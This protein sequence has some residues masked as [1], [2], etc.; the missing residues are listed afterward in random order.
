[1]RGENVYVQGVR[2]LAACIVRKRTIISRYIQT[3]ARGTGARIGGVG[4]RPGGV[5]GEMGNGINI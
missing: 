1:M 5:R 3:A 4:K 2:S